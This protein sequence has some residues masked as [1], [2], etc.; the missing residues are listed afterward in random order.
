[1]NPKS[2]TNI[3]AMAILILLSA[4]MLQCAKIGTISGG[5]KDTTAPVLRRSTP[6][7][8]QAE[9]DGK[10]VKIKFDEYFQ[11]DQVEQ[12]FL[13]S[14][15]HDSIKPKIKNKGKFLIIK[16][17]EEL[18]KDTTYTLQFFDAIKDFNEGNKISDFKFTFSTGAI[19]DSFAVAGQVFDAESLAFEKNILVGLYGEQTNF[20]DS[21]FINYK[22]D[23][24]T[25]TDTAGRFKVENIRPGRYKVVAL[26]DINETQRFD[27]ENEKIAFLKTPIE[28]H[29]ERYVRIDSLPAGTILHV[30]G[31][32]NRRLDTLP[33]DTVIIQNIL[34]TTPN[35]LKLYTFEEKHLIQ[36]ITER[37]RDMRSRVNI[38][39]NK[40]MGNDTVL[41]THVEDTLSVPDMIYDYNY[42]RDSLTLWLRDTADINNDTL[43]LRVTFATLDSINNPITETD[44]VNAKYSPP[45]K[46]V[47]SKDK[48]EK[49]KTKDT[50]IDSLHFRVKSNFNGDFD[51]EK[52]IKITIPLPLENIDT[53][54][55][56]LYEVIDSSFAENLSQK[57]V[58]TVRLDSANYRL[59]FRR[60]ILGDI[61]WYPTFDSIVRPDWYA[62][63]Y[64]ANRDTVFI[65]V[66]DSVMIHKS[67]FPNLIKYRYDYY[68]GQTVKARDSVSTVIIN[69][70]VLKYNRPSRDTIT[71][72]LEKPPTRGVE[73]TSIN[74]EKLS[75][76]AIEAVQ[77]YDEI[78]LVLH[79]TAAINKDTLALKFNTFDRL[80][81]NKNGKLIEK[82]CKDTLFAIYKIKFQRL[83]SPRLLGTDTIIFPFERQLQSKPEVTLID[84]PSKGTS[85]YKDSLSL[86]RDT[87]M[88]I[89][90]DRHFRQLDTIKY[91]ISY[92]NL[93][94]D[95]TDIIQTDTLSLIRPKE[96]KD[97]DPTGRRRRSDIGK[98]GQKQKEEDKKNMTK[99]TLKFPLDYQ[100]TADTLNAKDKIITYNFEPGKQYMLEI[101]DSTFTSIYGTPNLYMSNKAKIREF[102]YYGQLTINLQNIGDI[103]NAPDI[104]EDI[105]PFENLDTS[106]ALHKRFDPRDTMTVQ[107]T[108]LS[109]GQILVCLCNTK[110]EIKYSK[111]ITADSIVKFEYILPAEYK[112]KLIHDRNANG[113]W[114][115]GKYIEQR[116][117]ERAMVYPKKQ[118]VKSKWT[119]ELEWKL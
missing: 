36:Y 81:R 107:H 54:K 43:K 40:P 97:G 79:D 60:P 72:K 118:V 58:K 100:M 116:Y 24:I 21:A 8:G 85:W 74:V 101:D 30:G 15:P 119:T 63:T 115:T 31:K 83:R 44:T 105:P 32:G 117:P 42:T 106:R 19:V 1:M 88:I 13:L 111:A 18:K 23:Y 73:V 53:S 64:S 68:L 80:V 6:D 114:D 95:E 102:E 27:L 2:A 71:I 20:A 70:K 29:A 62:A 86:K 89:S 99:A 7:V 4:S 93:A 67:K 76:N 109:E 5:D 3:I 22:P 35:N 46:A 51:I 11:L 56:K 34:Y 52:P 25:R 59:V 94:A 110:E 65:E 28:T 69:Q 66:K 37:N 104:D 75:E 77:K 9:Y 108:T 33:N 47:A 103:E 91:T 113:K 57:L 16:F 14:P 82:V 90:A 45:K 84:F 55:I 61:V 12:K 38:V 17:K 87:F 98:E 26:K 10:K 96:K 49:N 48:T 78:T 50:G 92:P 39:F 112:I 41:V